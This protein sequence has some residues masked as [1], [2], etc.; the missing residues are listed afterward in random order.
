[1][2]LRPRWAVPWWEPFTAL[3]IGTVLNLGVSLSAYAGVLPTAALDREWSTMALAGASGGLVSALVHIGV[4]CLGAEPPTRAEIARALVEG[5]F[6]VIVGAFCAGYLGGPAAARFIPS[7]SAS[8]LRAV[9]FGV[10]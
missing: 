9:G 3:G 10:G 6:A 4:A 7:A 2:P 8:D 1:M 5:L